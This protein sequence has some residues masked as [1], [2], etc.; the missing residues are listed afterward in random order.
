MKRSALAAL[1][2]ILAV[3]VGASYGSGGKERDITRSF[4]KKE[5]IK[6]E[7]VSASV[8]IVGAKTDKIQI[9]VQN[10]YT[11]AEDVEN[12]FR[13]SGKTLRLTERIL[14]ST[15][16]EATWI[17]TVPESIEIDFSTA[18]GYLELSDLTG[19]FTVSTAS[20]EIT[21]SNCK[22]YFRISTASGNIT[23][24]E[25]SGE[26]ELST[27]SGDVRGLAVA[28][29]DVSSFSTASG[30]VDVRLARSPEHDLYLGSA[31]GSVLLDYAGNPVS[32]TFRFEAKEHD[33]VIEAPYGF[34]SE[35]TFRRGGDRYIR[36]I[37]TKGTGG[38]KIGI[39]TASGEAV[40]KE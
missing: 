26:F 22:G 15:N 2:L 12:D 3:A 24:K 34:D 13:E 4:E 37:F 7:T 10:R 28:I 18:S 25:C 11:P 21:M 30:G 9:E 1:L 38:P 39:G 36:K 29:D 40:L 35:E 27:A 14:G 16:G 8:E 31:S 20:G 32:G 23:A 19:G 33:G 5:R 17:L 6:I